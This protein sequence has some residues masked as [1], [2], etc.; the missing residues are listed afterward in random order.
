LGLFT[1]HGI[2]ESLINL[3]IGRFYNSPTG[4]GGVLATSFYRETAIPKKYEMLRWTKHFSFVDFIYDDEHKS[5][6]QNVI[7]AKK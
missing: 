3:A 6:D 4:G 1:L 7:I 5:F 2:L